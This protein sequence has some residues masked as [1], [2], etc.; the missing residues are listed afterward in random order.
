MIGKDCNQTQTDD[1]DSARES[2][3][4]EIH[5]S[6]RQK[7]LR[8]EKPGRQLGNISNVVISFEG[9]GEKAQKPPLQT[10]VN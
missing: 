5:T 3:R 10:P 7:E 9:H 6:W 2:K 4:V 8:Y 1:I